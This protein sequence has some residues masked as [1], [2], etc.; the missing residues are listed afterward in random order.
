MDKN[1]EKVKLN[2]ELLDKVS[3]GEDCDDT[4]GPDEWL[5]E[6][7]SDGNMYGY[8]N[9]PNCVARLTYN[10]EFVGAIYCPCCK[11][12]VTIES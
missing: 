4:P 8:K 1:S 9:C 11:K 12:Y 2:D 3:G 5:R 10:P 7:N 6:E